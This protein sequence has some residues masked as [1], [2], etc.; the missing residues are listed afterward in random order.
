MGQS[1]RIKVIDYEDDPFFDKWKVDGYCSWPERLIGIG[2]ASTFPS[3]ED[4]SLMYWE[5]NMREALRHEIVHAYLYE[6]GLASNTFA[7]KTPWA[8]NEEMVDWF[9]NQG[10]KIYKTWEE[11]SCLYKDEE[12]ESK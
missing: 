5:N 3:M 8:K 9:A 4:E 2:D 11:C 10:P 6:S 7:P 1:W 12:K